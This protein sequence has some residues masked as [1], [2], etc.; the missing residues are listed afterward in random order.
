MGPI[1]ALFS[2]AIRQT[3]VNRKIWLT[4]L[5]LAAPCILVLVIRSVAPPIR[6]AKSLWEMYHVLAHVL[7]VWVLVPLVCMMHG[8]AL[9]GAEAEAGT[10][11]HLITRRLR[12][13][14]TCRWSWGWTKYSW[15]V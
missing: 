15:C 12:R 1:A 8:T 2:F 6:E 3:L 11:V 13:S 14:A 10:I 4:V 9:I 5:M 7:L